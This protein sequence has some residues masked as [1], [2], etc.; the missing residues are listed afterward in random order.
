M[1]ATGLIL[2]IILKSNGNIPLLLIER[3]LS[4]SK[5]RVIS[6]RN[7]DAHILESMSS[8]N[9]PAEEIQISSAGGG[10]RVCLERKVAACVSSSAAVSPSCARQPELTTV[11]SD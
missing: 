1:F 2:C 11:A 5:Q 7:T 3:A 4:I 8:I 10:W 6:C 9:P